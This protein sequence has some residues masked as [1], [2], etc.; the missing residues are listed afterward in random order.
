[1]NRAGVTIVTCLAQNLQRV[2]HD[3]VLAQKDIQDLLV[4]GRR[5]EDIAMW[6]FMH[7]KKY[8]VSWS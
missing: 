3:G 4:A 1:L 8:K 6:L 5:I 2:I 7:Y